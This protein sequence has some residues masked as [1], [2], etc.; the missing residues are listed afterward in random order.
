MAALLYRAGQI[1]RLT[2]NQSSYL[3]RQMSKYR[4]NEP[5]ST[6]FEKEQPS[7]LKNMLNLFTNELGYSMKDFA[8]T[9][10]LEE[11]MTAHILGSTAPQERKLKLVVS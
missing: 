2:K 11:K 3:W 8:D 9:F 7:T 4:I 6:H 10:D 5:E 1:G